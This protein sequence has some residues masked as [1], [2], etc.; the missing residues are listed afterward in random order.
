MEKVVLFIIGVILGIGA[1]VFYFNV[2]K[3]KKKNEGSAGGFK[4][5]D[6]RDNQ[7]T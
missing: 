3:D 1:A 4:L 2:K 7:T 6:E 5:P